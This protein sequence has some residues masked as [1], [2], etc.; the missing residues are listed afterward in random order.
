MKMFKNWV[1]AAILICGTCIVAALMLNSC[2]Q[3]VPLTFNASTYEVIASGHN[4]DIRLSVTFSDSAITDIQVLE[5][6]ETPHVGDEVFDLV[7]PKI[8]KANGTEVDAVSGATVTR[9]ALIEGVMTAASMA[10][11]SDIEQFRTKSLPKEEKEPVEGTWD[12]VIIGAGGAGLAA[13]AEAAQQGNTVLVIEKNAEMGGNTLVSGGIFQS[14]MPYMVWDP[15]HPDATTGVGYDGKTYEKAKSGPGCIKDLETI[16]HWEEKEFDA[17]YYTNHP[18]VPGNISELASHGV[19]NE[20]MPVLQALKAEISEYLAWA[21]PKLSR[22]VPET[23]LTLFSTLNLHIFQTYY[24]GLRQS[25]DKKEWVYSDVRMVRQMVEQGQE[26]KPWLAS[27]GVSFL[28]K[29]IIIVGALWFRGNKMLGADIDTDDDGT[30]EHYDGNWGAYIM[31]PYTMFINSNKENRV[32]KST[33]ARELIEEGGRVKGVKAMMVDGTPVTAYARKG[34][35]IATGG[36]AANIRKVIDSNRYWNKQYLTKFMASTNRS[37]LQGDGLD[38]A[39]R[40]GAALTGMGWTQLMPLSYVE[41]G[42][43]A[44]G[45]VSDAVFISTKNGHRFVDEASERDVLSEKAF[46]NGINFN[47]KQGAYLYIGGE[48]TTEPN[49]VRGVDVPDKQYART[50]AQ[51]PEL[52]KTLKINISADTILKTIRNYDMAVM[53]GKEPADVSKRYAT[54]TIGKVKR[55]PDG[56]YDKSTYSLDNAMLTIRVLA[57]ATHHTMGGLVVDDKRHVID[58]N[59]KPIP[60]LY[61]AGEVTG[62]IHGGNRLGGNALT[63]IL[64]SGRIAA[65]SVTEDTK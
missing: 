58:N 35:I 11:V 40:M 1:L 19:H 64:V 9:G 10:Q 4:G 5:H 62:G 13:A 31:A 6:H 30:P 46:E 52:L 38:M 54:N 8:I 50:P 21:N 34:V 44:F 65:T 16:L 45:S 7:I 25:N 41:Y 56:T 22:G 23:D 36:Y 33:T 20:Y 18:Y 42:H 51:L 2:K 3:E 24:G 57:P 17:K 27:M 55:H 53:D 37:S 43:L 47:G 28:E 48:E 39:E 49:E 29:Q 61:A 26:L 59:G 12:V 60:G 63:E 32:M 15:A 14:V